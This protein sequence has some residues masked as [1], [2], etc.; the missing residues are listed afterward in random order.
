[1]KNTP[2][3][4]LSGVGLP[5]TLLGLYAF[6]TE[7]ERVLL[8][9]GMLSLLTWLK[10][11]PT[12]AAPSLEQPRRRERPSDD[13]A[14]YAPAV[15]LDTAD[16]T[17]LGKYHEC[18][19]RSAVQTVTKAETLHLEKGDGMDVLHGVVSDSAVHDDGDGH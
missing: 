17:L 1:M 18:S 4:T 15:F 6:P 9:A 8:C 12:G 5:I 14:A 13:A 19:T 10:L 3:I 2:M 7:P 11:E 16:T